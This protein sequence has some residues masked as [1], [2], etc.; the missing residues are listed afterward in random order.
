MSA[1]VQ[2]AC[3]CFICMSRDYIQRHV[4]EDS[5]YF[6]LTR[7]IEL[8]QGLHVYTVSIHFFC[9]V[10]RKT[11]QPSTELSGGQQSC[12]YMHKMSLI[13][14]STIKRNSYW[15]ILASK[16]TESYAAFFLMLPIKI[17]VTWDPEHKNEVRDKS[18]DYNFTFLIPCDF[19]F[20]CIWVKEKSVSKCF[21]CRLKKS[22]Y[23][24]IRRYLV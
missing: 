20:Y 17:S 23:I 22:A 3:M 24:S 8:H 18:N 14:L 2:S 12:K 10:A 7:V 5:G 15:V 16:H 19:S 13:G 6:R 4:H 21:Y 9:F 1:V 11:L